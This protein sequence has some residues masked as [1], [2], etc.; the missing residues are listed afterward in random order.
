VKRL[1]VI[2]LAALVFPAAAGAKEFRSVTLC[3]ASGCATDSSPSDVGPLGVAFMDNLMP[4]TSAPRPQ[5]YYRVEI[6]VA[7]S[8]SWTQWYVPGVQILSNRDENAVPVWWDVRFERGDVLRKLALQ[9]KPF[10][11]P[12]IAK[13]VVAGR[14]AAR[15]NAYV[16]LLGGLRVVS[17]PSGNGG[18]IE[19]F[20]TPSGRSPWL[21]ST[22]SVRFRSA[23]SV[24]ILYDAVRVPKDLANRIRADAGLPTVRS[25]AGIGPVKWGALLLPIPILLALGLL[26][27]R[28]RGRPSAAPA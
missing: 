6:D 25:S 8:G 9:V 14:R 17:G 28:R 16:P 26:W 7:G 18:W 13:V 20:V 24:A 10:P 27:A 15:P 11:A 22:T 5:A 1:L 3:G 23:S 4:T 12:T 21:E 2:V 19:L